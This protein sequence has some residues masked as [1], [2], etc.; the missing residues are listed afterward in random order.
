MNALRDRRKGSTTRAM[1][2]FVNVHRETGNSRE[3]SSQLTFVVM[4][5]LNNIFRHIWRFS[6]WRMSIG[7]GVVVD[8]TLQIANNQPALDFR[9]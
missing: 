5:G 8:P 9:P 7:C 6:Y 3:I 1:T 4:G 2:Y